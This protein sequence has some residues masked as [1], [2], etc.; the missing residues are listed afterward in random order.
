VALKA[1]FLIVTSAA[2]RMRLAV[3]AERWEPFLL[4]DDGHWQPVFDAQPVLARTGRLRAVGIAELLT[5][6]LA[7]EHG[8]TVLHYDSD[9]EIAAEVLDF[10][11]R[12]VVPR[13]T[14]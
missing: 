6:V 13:G 1:R 10:E 4:T 12:W 8:M 11:Y 5:A 9:F 7:A 2:A 14:V 3:V